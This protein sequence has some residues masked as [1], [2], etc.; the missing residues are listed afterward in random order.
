MGSLCIFQE[1]FV[2]AE[3][4]LLCSSRADGLIRGGD[5]ISWPGK[6]CRRDEQP[7]GWR[8]GGTQRGKQAL[9]TKACSSAEVR[10]AVTDAAGG[11]KD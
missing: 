7:Q 2:P 10:A 5:A 8:H 3:G 9:L 1:T 6:Q 11:S 4:N